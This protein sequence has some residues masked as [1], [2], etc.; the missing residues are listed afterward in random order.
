[1][2]RSSFHGVARIACAC[3]VAVH[4]S[5]VLVVLCFSGQCLL[6]D[7]EYMTPAMSVQCSITAMAALHRTVDAFGRSFHGDGNVNAIGLHSHN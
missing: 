2:L 1:M 6:N 4:C 7:F 5:V 3:S